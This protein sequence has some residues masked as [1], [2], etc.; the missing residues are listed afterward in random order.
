MSI[1]SEAQR[2][3]LGRV[4]GID[5]GTVRVGIA[6]TDPDRMLASPLENY[7]R[8]SESKDAEYFRQLVA[9]ENVTLFVVG[10]PIHLDGRESEKS[11]EARAYG[12]WLT[13]ITGIPTTYFDERFTSAEGRATFARCRV[14]QKATKKTARHAGSPNHALGLP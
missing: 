4:A 3:P 8:R 10:L 2:K 6:I 13:E 9:E 14:D 7:T 11:I 1:G 5:Y 12:R